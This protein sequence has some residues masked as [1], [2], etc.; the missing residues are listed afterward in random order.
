MKLYAYK[1]NTLVDEWLVFSVGG[2][3]LKNLNDDRS[4]SKKTVY[5]HSKMDDI[6]KYT[7]DNNMSLIDY[8]KT[9][10][11]DIFNY[12]DKVFEVMKQ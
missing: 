1:E 4:L 5:P 8:V 10:D 3:N 9:F 12:L 7:N 6:I 2:G 11:N